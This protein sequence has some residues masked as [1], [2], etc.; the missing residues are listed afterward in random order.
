[1]THANDDPDDWRSKHPQAEGTPLVEETGH[2]HVTV[3]RERGAVSV[4]AE[5]LPMPTGPNGTYEPVLRVT[6][7]AAGGDVTITLDDDAA[8]Q[9][10]YGLHNS[11][12]SA[13]TRAK[14]KNRVDPTASTTDGASDISAPASDDTRLLYSADPDGE[15]PS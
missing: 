2:S 1:M 13:R 3:R 12:S 8:E 9:L 11:L 14:R 7:R 4:W 5:G 15:G 10:V 6:L